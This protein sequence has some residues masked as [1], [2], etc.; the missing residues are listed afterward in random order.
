MALTDI[1]PL[2]HLHR[3]IN[4]FFYCDKKNFN[5]KYNTGLGI[6]FYD[7]IFFF[8]GKKHEKY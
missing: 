8:T 7:C 2:R 5:T 4:A 1:K 6:A 3:Y